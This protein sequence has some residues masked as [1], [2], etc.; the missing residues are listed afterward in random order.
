MTTSADIYSDIIKKADRAL[1]Y[2]KQSGKCGYYFYD[3]HVDEAKQEKQVDLKRLVSSLKE[4]GAYSGSLSVEYREFAKLYDYIQHLGERYEYNVHLILIRLEPANQNK[5][6]I[7]EKEHAMTCME[8]TIQASLRSVDIST[9][10]SGEQFVVILTDAQNEYVEVITK[11]ISE[12]FHKIYDRKLINVHF[13]IA[14][15]LE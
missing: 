1:Y 8:K 9:R 13:D 7:D 2:V 10:F 14:A 4:Q 5:L 12:N 6:Y 11:R 15:L 3:N